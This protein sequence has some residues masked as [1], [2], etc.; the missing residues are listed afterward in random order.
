MQRLN[1]ARWEVGRAEDSEAID[2][3]ISKIIEL[4]ARVEHL[5]EDVRTMAHGYVKRHEKSWYVWRKPNVGLVWQVDANMPNPGPYVVWTS[6]GWTNQFG[7]Y[8]GLTF[9]RDPFTAMQAT[10]APGT[11]AEEHGNTYRTAEAQP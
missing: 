7:N 9:Y 6:T 1:A 8:N 3:A 4:R 5:E 10:V 2:D 11:G